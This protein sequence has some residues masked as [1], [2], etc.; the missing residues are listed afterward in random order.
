MKLALA[1][2]GTGGHIYPALALAERFAGEG[3]FA[4][5]DVLYLGMPDGL[6]AELVRAAGLRFAPVRAAPLL[7]GRPRALGTTLARNALGFGDALAAFHRFAPDALIAT[8]GYAAVP[9]VAALRAVRTLG[10]SRARIALLEPNLE[11]GLANRL[12]APLADEVWLGAALPGR[13]LGARERL[14]GI[15]VRASF[16][17]PRAAAQ[18]RA[19]LGLEPGR[20]TVVAFGGSQGARTL[21]ETFAALAERGALGERQVLLV[22]GRANGEALAARLRSIPQI[23]VVGYLDD[24]APGYAAADLVVARA[25]ASTLA[26]LAASGTPALLVPYPFA[27]GAHQLHN[28]RAVAA[29]GA[30]LVLLDAELTP[31]RL[32]A[33]LDR[34]LEPERLAAMRA[35][36]CGERDPAAAIVARVKAWLGTNG[37]VP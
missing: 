11:A 16:A 1:G 10:R 31:E 28:A 21:N 25:G 26:E 19:E 22:A 4:P 35:A 2:G 34:A 15:P 32:A 13:K 6:E 8:G 12:L 36:V 30:A 14:V 17:R 23:R 7:R 37:S 29:R 18:A 20:T 24:P 5:L 9:A 33:E 27:T 3:A